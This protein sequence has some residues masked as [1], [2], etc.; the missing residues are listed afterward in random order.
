M[1]ETSEIEDSIPAMYE[2]FEE[3]L[4]DIHATVKFRT[5]VPVEDVFVKTTT[6]LFAGN[7][8]K[9]LSF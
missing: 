4:N 1:N 9:Y 5:A 8:Y 6:Y 2:A 7:L 3:T